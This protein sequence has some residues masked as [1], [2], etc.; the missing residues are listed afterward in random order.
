MKLMMCKTFC[1]MI[2]MYFSIL[3]YGEVYHAKMTKCLLVVTTSQGVKNIEGFG[4][5]KDEA[6]LSAITE[7]EKELKDECI[8]ESEDQFYYKIFN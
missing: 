2:A 6:K 3:C 5:N 7:C 8:I 1:I 4:R